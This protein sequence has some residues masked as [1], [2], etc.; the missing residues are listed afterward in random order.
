MLRRRA[1]SRTVFY[2][3]DDLNR[4][5]IASSTAASSTSFCEQY[6][7]NAI[8]NLLYKGVRTTSAPTTNRSLDLERSSS[9]YAYITDGSQSGLD[10]TGDLSISLW[11]KFESALG[12]NQN[13]TFISRTIMQRTRVR[14]ISATTTREVLA[15]SVRGS[16][17]DRPSATNPRRSPRASAAVRGTTSG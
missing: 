14:T 1:A 17:R 8:G 5:L 10:I 3:Y 16:A 7:Y 2:T 11:A 13:Y 4:L 12:T 6:Q 15:N 9:Q